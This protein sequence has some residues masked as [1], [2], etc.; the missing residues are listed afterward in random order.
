MKPQNAELKRQLENV[1]SHIEMAAED[2]ADDFHNAIAHA[3]IALNQ[4][5][6]IVAAGKQARAA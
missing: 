4:L 2:A 1:A 3:G 6:S 5:R